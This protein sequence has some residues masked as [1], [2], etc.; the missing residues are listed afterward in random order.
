MRIQF[1][2]DVFAVVVVADDLVDLCPPWR[3]NID[4]FYLC[5]CSKGRKRDI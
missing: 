3:P 1:K 5:Q 2:S 4:D